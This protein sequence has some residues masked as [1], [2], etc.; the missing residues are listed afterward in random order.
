MSKCKKEG[1]NNNKNVCIETV[2]VAIVAIFVKNVN[3][4]IGIAWVFLNI[5]KLMVNY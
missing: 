1:C 2:H 4:I 3:L 5:K